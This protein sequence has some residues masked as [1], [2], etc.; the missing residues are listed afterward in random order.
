MY[1]F[2]KEWYIVVS[3]RARPLSPELN[4][5][6]VMRAVK[7]EPVEYNSFRSENLCVSLFP[8]SASSQSLVGTAFVL[9][10]AS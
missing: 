6:V 7:A 9:I 5:A 2:E 3:E 4:R 8:V 10:A 1:E